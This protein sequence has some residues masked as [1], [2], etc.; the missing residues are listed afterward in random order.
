MT[1][2]IAN[3]KLSDIEFRL[4]QLE[5]K[6]KSIIEDNNT[7]YNNVDGNNLFE[8]IHFDI[9]KLTSQ[10]YENTASINTFKDDIDKLKIKIEDYHI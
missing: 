4:I 10:T 8:Q 5:N 3:T 9:K 2:L 7:K 1:T 6:V